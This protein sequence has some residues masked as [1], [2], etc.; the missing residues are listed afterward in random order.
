MDSAHFRLLFLDDDLEYLDHAH[1]DLNSHFNN[2]FQF[3]SAPFM[4]VLTRIKAATT[5]SATSVNITSA[6]NKNGILEFAECTDEL[7][8]VYMI[9]YHYDVEN[10]CFY[11]SD[12][13]VLEAKG[14]Y[15]NDDC[16]VKFDFKC[17]FLY[18]AEWYNCN[19]LWRSDL[20]C[21]L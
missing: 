2:W 21:K 20:G 7:Y 11:H 3:S 8:I 6:I 15:D 14:F 13:V 5:P 9:E 18:Q 16:D 17:V 19:Q 12:P 1:H 4:I 10:N